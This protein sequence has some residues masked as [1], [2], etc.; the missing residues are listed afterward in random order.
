MTEQTRK[1]RAAKLTF[2][3][4]MIA[5]FFAGWLLGVGIKSGAEFFGDTAE[6]RCAEGAGCPRGFVQAHYRSL[7]CTYF[8]LLRPAVRVSYLVEGWQGDLDIPAA[9][10]ESG[11]SF[12]PPLPPLRNLSEREIERVK[13]GDA[14]NVCPLVYPARDEPERETIEVLE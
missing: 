5:V 12:P 9:A 6:E 10:T 8:R 2:F 4:V 11:E 14:W 7:D 3:A 1:L 13:A